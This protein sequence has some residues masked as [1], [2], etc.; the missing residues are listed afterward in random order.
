[1][2]LIDAHAHIGTWADFFVPQPGA[3]W[4]VRTM[5]HLGVEAAGIS[6]MFGV[7]HDAV[8]GNQ[9][10]LEA[11]AAHPG[12]LYAWL[13][14]SPHDHD[15]VA[16]LADQLDQPGVWGIKIHPDTHEVTLDDPRYEPVLQLAADHGAPVLT[17]TQTQSPWSDPAVAATVARRTSAQ[18]LM[19]HGGLS[20]NG[21]LAA[22]RLAAEVDNLWFETASSRLTR[23]WLRRVV[24]EAGADKV[25]FGTDALFLDPRT[26]VGRFIAA[27]LTDA[28]R[29]AVGAG[30]LVRILGA[31]L[32]TPTPQEAS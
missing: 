15:A 28:E 31:R 8:T 7:G 25:L 12:R 22:A 23:H 10:T 3:D 2:R 27:D 16:R 24:A 19:G 1:M 13:V 21:L 14:A 11:V 18:L 5:D 30:N 4:F 9:L 29:A 26:G 32:P 17:H 20:L 6:H